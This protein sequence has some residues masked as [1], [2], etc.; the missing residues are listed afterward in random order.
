MAIRGRQMAARLWS[1]WLNDVPLQTSGWRIIPLV[2]RRSFGRDTNGVQTACKAVPKEQIC[3][4]PA[5]QWSDPCK[6]DPFI[7]CIALS[8]V[9]VCVWGEE[10]HRG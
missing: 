4:I 10:G 7:S 5:G 1:L 8:A 3:S 2:D 6:L 9:F